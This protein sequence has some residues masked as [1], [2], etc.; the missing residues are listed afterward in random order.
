M[1]Q[2]TIKQKLINAYRARV[3]VYHRIGKIYHLLLNQKKGW[4]PG[5]RIAYYPIFEDGV[6]GEKYE[7]PRALV[8]KPAI[9]NGKEGIDFREVPL[10]FLRE[11]I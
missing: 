3:W 4:D 11:N 9:F 6:T 8:E 1:E 2:E 5:W 7:E 10:R